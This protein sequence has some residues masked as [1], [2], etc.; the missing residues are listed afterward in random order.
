MSD[1][2]VSHATADAGRADS[3][4]EAL[5]GAGYSVATGQREAAE[6]PAKLSLVLWSRASVD[7]ETASRRCSIRP[8][9]RTRAAAISA[10]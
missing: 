4:A 9:R 10:C 8:R 7:G 2:F 6:P 5:R 1:I 3:I